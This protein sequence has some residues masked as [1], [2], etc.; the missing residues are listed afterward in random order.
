VHEPALSLRVTQ[1]WWSNKV[2]TKCACDTRCNKALRLHSV[3]QTRLCM[4]LRSVCVSHKMVKQ[5]GAQSACNDDGGATRCSFGLLVTQGAVRRSACAHSIFPGSDH[6]SALSLLVTQGTQ[7]VSHKMVC[8]KALTHLTLPQG[9]NRHYGI[10][11]DYFLDCACL[12]K[13]CSLLLA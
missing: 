4:S 11:R 6:E 2:L 5:Q 12:F 8:S 1:R 9:A 3:F 7:P 13:T 10:S